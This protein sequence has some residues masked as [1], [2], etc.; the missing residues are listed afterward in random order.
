MVEFY[1]TD[2]LP[3]DL[4]RPTPGCGT[5]AGHAQ[6]VKVREAAAVLG[7]ESAV[8]LPEEPEFV[9]EAGEGVASI[10]AAV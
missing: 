5:A 6:A 9:A 4:T 1:A 8:L 2:Q 10:L 7:V 3:R